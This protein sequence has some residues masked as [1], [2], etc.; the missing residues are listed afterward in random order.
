MIGFSKTA[1]GGLSTI[2]VAIYALYLPTKESTAAVLLLL[3]VGDLV[4]LSMYHREGD[5]SLI[6]RLLPAVIPGLILGALFLNVVDDTTLRR[7]IGAILVMLL[8]LQLVIKIKGAPPT[9]RQEHRLAAWSAGTAAGF[10][11][12][13]A[14]SAGA[15]MTLYLSSAGVDKKKFIGTNAWFFFVI[16]VTK[17]PF[18]FS[19]GL[20]HWG[21]LWLTLQLAPFVVVGGFIGKWAA[22]RMS[23]QVFDVL[24]LAASAVAALALI[25]S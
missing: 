1:I 9:A 22:D 18:S 7:A 19:L 15:V 23:Q 2:A 25:L 6:R 20:L 16:N 13:T 24:V 10:T 4:A 21:T 8:L 5:W 12:M 17:L 3:I 14:N 11:T